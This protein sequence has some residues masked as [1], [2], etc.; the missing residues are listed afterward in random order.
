L[1][2]GRSARLYQRLLK[3]RRLFS[4]I[5]AYVTGNIDPGLFIITSKP[6]EGVSLETA[7]VAIWEELDLLKNDLVEE[8]E[9]QKI[10][11]KV[12]SSLVFSET[13]IL[14][15]AIDLAMFE[16][17]GDANLI[18]QQTEIYRNITA[19]NLRTQ[20]QKLFRKENCSEL[21]YRAK[22]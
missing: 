18:N 19:E 4:D 9:L 1:S 2:R 6:A 5:D 20:A 14:T 3:D 10:K 16:V 7:E 8:R 15:K 13:N 17:Q 11:N 21:F 12:E 22:K